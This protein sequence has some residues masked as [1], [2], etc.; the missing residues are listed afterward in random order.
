MKIS[1]S[2]FRILK[3]IYFPH[4][5]TGMVQIYKTHLAMHNK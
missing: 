5:L 1:E 3:D 2:G 4:Q